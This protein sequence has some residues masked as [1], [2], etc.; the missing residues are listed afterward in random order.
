LAQTGLHVETELDRKDMITGMPVSVITNIARPRR[1][2]WTGFIA[3]DE[4]ILSVLRGDNDLVRRMDLTHPQM[5]RPLFHVWNV[6]L[7]EIAWGEFG[8]FS[9]MQS[10]LYN[11]KQVTFK[12]ESTKSWQRSIFQ[13]EI[14][15]RFDLRLGREMPL[16]ERS[17]LHERYAHLAADELALMEER[18]TNMRFSEMSPY[19]IMCY[20]FYGGHTAY[21]SDPIAI[22]Y[23]FGLR[24]LEEIGNAFQ[25]R[26][27][28]TLTD[29]FAH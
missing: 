9:G 22:A 19:Y 1:F 17:F 4:D 18:F 15:G 21:R 2:S 29:H 10:F 5:A 26:L 27:Y 12:A 11:G 25:E 20:G 16:A 6:V 3:E 8:R 24:G 14:Q 7:A 13:D 28:E 23:L